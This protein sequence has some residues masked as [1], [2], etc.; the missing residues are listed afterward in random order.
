MMLAELFQKT[1]PPKIK[2]Q[3]IPVFIPDEDAKRFLL[4]Q[5][6]YDVFNLLLERGVFDQK[7]CAISL[8]FDKFGVLQTIQR[9]DFLYSK[10]NETP[11]QTG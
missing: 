7:N 8:H 10:R 5:K 3:K 9:A 4:F 1:M 6:H 2:P 11:L